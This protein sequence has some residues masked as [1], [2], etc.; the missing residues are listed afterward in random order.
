MSRFC[1][2]IV[3][4]VS[5]LSTQ[6]AVSERFTL[7]NQN[8]SVVG[9]IRYTRSKSDD[10]LIDIA[11]EFDL[12]YDQIVS[13]NPGVNRWIPGNGTQV[14]LPHLYILP[15]SSRRGVVLNIADLRIYYYPTPR[16]GE[17]QEVYTYPVSIGRMDWRTPLGVTRVVKKERDP[18]WR[19]PPSIRLEHARDGDPLPE[20]I[21]GGAADNP[22]GR[23][24]LRLGIPTYLIHGVDERKAFGIG[25]RVTHG[26]IRMYPEDIEPF[27]G[28]VSVNTPV[29]LVDEPVK[30]GKLGN[31]VF[32]SVHQPLDEGE[33]ESAP[34]LARVSLAQ[35]TR[36]LTNQL[37]VDVR[38][39]ANLVADI[40]EKGDGI[41]HEIGFSDS[42]SSRSVVTRANAVVNSGD[43]RDQINREYSEAI[44]RYLR[45]TPAPIVREAPRR[46]PVAVTDS[47]EDSAV[48]RYLEERY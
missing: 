47:E 38:Y 16:K 37:G 25:M 41:P 30:V 29:L 43:S 7:E 35:V 36:Y 10:T 9:E 8:D 40:T 19:P 32:L 11:R 18:V 15:G 6:E 17:A 44:E 46:T 31:R 26:C 14:T 45:D 34:P 13:A 12:G 23:F 22:L 42:G 1:L 33:D 4:V 27:F 2:L 3:G 20:F 28:L 48:R 21:P 39:D 5:F 24:A